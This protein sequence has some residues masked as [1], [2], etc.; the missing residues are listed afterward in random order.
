MPGLYLVLLVCVLVC[1]VAVDYKYKLV[2]FK[3]ATRA[4]KIYGLSLLIFIIWD[5]L[6]IVLNI[7]FIGNTP[8]LTGIIIG[9]EFPIEEIFFLTVLIYNPL[10]VYTFLKERVYV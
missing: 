5:V 3:D 8:F 6:G 1:F 7:F 9:P 10:I 2:L 4:I